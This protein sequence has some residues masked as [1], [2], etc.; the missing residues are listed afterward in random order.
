V[1]RTRPGNTDDIHFLKG[2]IADKSGRDLAGYDNE[3]NGIHVGGGY[4]GNGIGG[5]RSGCGDGDTDLTARP[6]KAVRRMNRR[7]LVTWQNMPNFRKRVELIVN[8]DDSASGIAE[9]RVN[10]FQLEAFQQYS[11][12]CELHTINLPV[13]D[14]RKKNLSVVEK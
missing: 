9:D 6:G 14:G 4:T 7:L 11:R 13:G 5:S 10:S 8:I 12:A 2:I 3:R 1:F